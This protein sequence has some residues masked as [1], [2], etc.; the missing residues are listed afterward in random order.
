MDKEAS[1]S[2]LISSHLPDVTAVFRYDGN[3][4]PCNAVLELLDYK[5][6]GGKTCSIATSREFFHRIDISSYILR[7]F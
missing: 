7:F 5:M 2:P 6:K 3:F 4:A 1:S